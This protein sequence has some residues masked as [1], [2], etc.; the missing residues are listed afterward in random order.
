MIHVVA[1]IEVA[2]GKR[3]DFLEEFHKLVPLVH[4]EQGCVEYGPAVDAETALAENRPD[5]VV[6]LEKWADLSALQA[7]LEAQHMVE[8][9][10]Q[11]K[12]LVRG[13]KLQVLRP[14]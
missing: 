10:E 5:T 3:E 12:S 1:T 11:V 7:H 8:F 13:T 14:A 6:V 9:R 2:A 4:A